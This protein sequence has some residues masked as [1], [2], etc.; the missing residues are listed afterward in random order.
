MMA[1]IVIW[2]NDAMTSEIILGNIS[3]NIMYRGLSPR[4]RDTFTKSRFFKLTTCDLNSLVGHGQLV[5]ARINTMGITPFT[6]IYA[7]M[8]IINGKLGITRKTF[9]NREMMSSTRPPK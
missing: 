5:S 2:K 8:T 4:E 6:V 3:L 1:A 9:V 7:A